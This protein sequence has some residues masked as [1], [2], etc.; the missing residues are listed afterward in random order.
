MRDKRSPPELAIA[1]FAGRAFFL[2]IVLPILL[3]SNHET[4][5]DESTKTTQSEL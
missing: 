1:Q 4:R 3:E 5:I 2:P